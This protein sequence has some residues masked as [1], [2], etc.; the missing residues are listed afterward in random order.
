MRS[1]KLTAAIAAAATLLMLAA[2]GASA[3]PLGHKHEGAASKCHIDLFA[4]PHTITSGESVEVFGQLRCP[5]KGASTAGQTVTVYGRSVGSPAFKVLGTP[6]TGAGGFY[7]LVQSDVTASSSYYASGLGARSGTRT[8][9]VAPVVTLNGPS[10]TVP[11][12]TGFR[13]RV[14]FTGA[15]TPADAGAEVVLQRETATSSEEWGAIQFGT[16]G[17]GGLYSITHAFGAPGD[18]NIR[19][20]VRP[21]GKFSVRGISNTLSY[22]ISQKQNPNLTIHTSAYSVPYG[23]P[24]TVSG[25]LAAGAGKTVTLLASTFGKEFAPVTTT[26]TTGGDYSF[27]VTPLQNTRYRV[28]GGGLK[29]AVLFEGVK[30]ILT[31]GASAKTVQAG[32]PLRFAGT[33]TPGTVGKLV[34]LERENSSGSGFH[35]VDGGTVEPGGTYSITDYIFGSGKAVFRVKIPGDPDNQ[36]ASSET[37]PVEVTPAPPSLLKPA[38]QPKVPNEGT[39]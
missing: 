34:Y 10:E 12:F 14:T 15:V 31:A 32:Q 35:V 23:S 33:V 36:Q 4:E 2:T 25:I 30:Y 17:E 9:R 39:V 16:V 5:H 37:F 8:V 28:T 20:V 1:I 26:T 24:V 6:T 19:V 29:S 22:G 18:A 13:S 3:R 7:S 21:Y 27:I 11:L 38:A